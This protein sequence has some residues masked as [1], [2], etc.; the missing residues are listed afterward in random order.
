MCKTVFL[1]S[2]KQAKSAGVFVTDRPYLC[3]VILIGKAWSLPKCSSF[4]VFPSSALPTYFRI[5]PKRFIRDKHSSLFSSFI[6]Y[7]EIFTTLA[8]LSFLANFFLCHQEFQ[9]KFIRPFQNVPSKARSFGNHS[10]GAVLGQISALPAK[11]R[12][13]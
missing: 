5:A 12:L 6:S 13:G 11:I 10:D 8:P 9:N 2:D 7:E 3:D 4:K 1:I